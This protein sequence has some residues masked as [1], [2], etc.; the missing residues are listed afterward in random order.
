MTWQSATIF[1]A[2]LLSSCTTPMSP[3]T[4]PDLQGTRDR[5][6]AVAQE[7]LAG[8]GVNAYSVPPQRFVWQSHDGPFPCG[9]VDQANGCFSPTT[10]TI[11]YNTQQAH[12]IRHEAGHA[13]L[14]ALG[15]GCWK[16]ISINGIGE[17]VLVDHHGCE[18]ER[19]C[20]FVGKTTNN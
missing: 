2:L 9:G 18:P 13:I 6:W 5:E 4:V 19:R 7:V 12:V 3:T 17:Q 11:D 8:W 15:Y 14:W 1:S 20:T 10:R 16:C